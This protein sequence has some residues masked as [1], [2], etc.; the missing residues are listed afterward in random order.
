MII[1]TL[2]ESNKMQ[3]DT[4]TLVELPKTPPRH[5][6]IVPPVHLGNVVPLD[7]VNLIHSHISCKWH[8]KNIILSN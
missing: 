8:L 7:F 5:G 6:R 2:L 4:N 3:F 1:I